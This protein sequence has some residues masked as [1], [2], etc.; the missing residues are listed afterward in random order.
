MIRFLT[1]LDFRLVFAFKMSML[2]LVAVMLLP[3]LA[4]P[5]LTK[6]LA[7]AA[8][9]TPYETIW[10]ALIVAVPAMLSPLLLAWLTNRSH[11][12]EKQQDYAR[13]DQVAERAER[14][15]RQ[16]EEAAR[17]LAEVG[18]RTHTRN[19]RDLVIVTIQSHALKGRSALIN[20]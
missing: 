10:L 1:W 9:D 14:V 8:T 20:A 4:E 6:R 5:D 11:R 13:Q 2:A 17:L 3:A 7:L 15:A 18:L 16:A 12:Q 19:S